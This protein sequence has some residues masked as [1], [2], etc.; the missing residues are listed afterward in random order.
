MAALAISSSLIDV[1]PF[2]TG[3]AIAMGNA[4]DG[5]RRNICRSLLIFAGSVA[6]TGPLLTW[7]VLVE[8]GWF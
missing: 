2:S 1:S 7:A 5:E 8:S 3:G 4:T 6:V